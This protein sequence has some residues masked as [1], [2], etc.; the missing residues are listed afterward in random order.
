MRKGPNTFHKDAERSCGGLMNQPQHIQKVFDKFTSEQIANNRL[1]LKASIDTVRWL[2][3]QACA[4]RG[5]D[6]SQS[7]INRGKFLEMLKLLCSY[8]EKVS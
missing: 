7:S 4:F 5:H 3:F 8:N 2:A 6:E 1:R